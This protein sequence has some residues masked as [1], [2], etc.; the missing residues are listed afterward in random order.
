[1]QDRQLRPNPALLASYKAKRLARA[2]KA[3]RSKNIFLFTE[4]SRTSV[5]VNDI[6]TIYTQPV[7]ARLMVVGY[8]DN[9]RYG[10]TQQEDGAGVPIKV[11]F[12]QMHRVRIVGG[13]APR[14][15]S[16]DLVMAQAGAS[17][18]PRYT[19]TLLPC[20]FILEADE[21][22]AVDLAYDTAMSEP[23]NIPTQAFIFFC[24]RVKDQLSSEDYLIIEDIKTYT[25]DHDYQRGIFLNCVSPSQEDIEF[26]TA[27]AGGIATCETRP[28]N[29]PLLITGVGT[30]LLASKL[31]ITDTGNGHSFS[32]NRAMRSSALNM[33]D[34]ADPSGAIQQA[35]AATAYPWTYYYQFPA[36]H[37]LKPGALLHCDIV[38]GGTDA[39]GNA[40]V[41]AQTGNILLFQ[42]ITV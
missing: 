34:G 8:S 11:I 19:S 35:D 28:A 21:Q 39:S 2:V 40:T 31:T 22:I 30:T 25:R 32:L 4:G 9:F 12:P 23:T 20:P 33:P 42:G 27:L 26:S 6:T 36:A 14:A 15:L 38:N 13:K 17:G 3:L 37:L 29:G 7:G 24:V 5:N 16:D 41:D 1:M 10:A 18:Q